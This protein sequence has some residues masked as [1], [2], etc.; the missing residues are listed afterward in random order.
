M[1]AGIRPDLMY[2]VKLARCTAS[3]SPKRNR[4]VSNRFW[5]FKNPEDTDALYGTDMISSEFMNYLIEEGY[6]YLMI[7]KTDR[8][9]CEEFGELFSEK[10]PEEDEVYVVDNQNRR[11]RPYDYLC[12]DE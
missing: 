8:Y 6:D 12:V 7:H 9:F 4:Q 1:H 2:L 11:L 10:K 5:C 3:Y